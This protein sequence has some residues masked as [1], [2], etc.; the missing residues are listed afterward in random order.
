MG[1]VAIVLA[2][3]V[4]HF[5]GFVVSLAQG[6]VAIHQDMQF[7]GIVIAN[8]ACAQVVGLADAIDRGCQLQDLCLYL[9]GQRLLHQVANAVAQQEDGH[10]DDEQTHH[11]RGDGVEHGPSL[12]QEDGATNAD[13]R[14]YRREGVAAMVPG[15]GLDGLRLQFACFPHRIAI[16]ALLEDH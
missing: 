8:A 3:Q 9:I 12:S 4:F 10:L 1:V 7:D 11:D 15:D 6:D 2:Q 13:G 16:D 5:G 14:T